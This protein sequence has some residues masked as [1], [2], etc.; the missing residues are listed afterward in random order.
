MAITP[1]LLNRIALAIAYLMV[2]NGLVLV[3]Y[4]FDK[5]SAQRKGLRISENTFHLLTLM[6]GTLGA[7]LGQK[8]FRHKT[9]KSSFQTVFRIIVAAQIFALFVAIFLVAIAL[10]NQSGQD[11]NFFDRP[12]RS[13]LESSFEY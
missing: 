3:L 11:K 9:R 6:G 7:I 5:Q 8:L 2:V 13:N 10:G 12:V 4:V 1:A